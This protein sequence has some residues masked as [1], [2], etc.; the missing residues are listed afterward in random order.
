MYISVH[1]RAQRS[2]EPGSVKLRKLLRAVSLHLTSSHF[3][4]RHPPLSPHPRHHP[5]D[6][7][8]HDSA[9]GMSAATMNGTDALKA[10]AAGSGSKQQV[11][12][13]KALDGARKQASPAADGKER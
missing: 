7:I 8:L 4:T 6:S 9:A 3:S 12:S 5:L 2:R 1:P 13:G 10:N 11:K